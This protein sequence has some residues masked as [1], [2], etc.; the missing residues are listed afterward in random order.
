MQKIITPADAVTELEKVLGVKAQDIILPPF[1]AA[2]ELIWAERQWFRRREDMMV[3]VFERY[4]PEGEPWPAGLPRFAIGVVMQSA[5][6]RT[7]QMYGFSA[8]SV[9]RALD[10]APLVQAYAAKQAHGKHLTQQM[11]KNAQQGLPVAARGKP[12]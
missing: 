12:S 4:V 1:P 10:L 8:E 6:G 9:A 7:S 5:A 2:G 3:T 11:L